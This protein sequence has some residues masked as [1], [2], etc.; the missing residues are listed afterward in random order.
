MDAPD[1]TLKLGSLSESAQADAAQPSDEPVDDLIGW[2]LKR[3][4][5]YSFVHRV[6]LPGLA[7]VCECCPVYSCSTYCTSIRSV[8]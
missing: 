4:D 6:P 5:E 1:V 8:D 3:D 2:H 7:E